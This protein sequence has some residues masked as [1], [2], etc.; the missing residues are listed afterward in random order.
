VD[1]KILGNGGAF[2][3]LST[4]YL[5]ESK[6][7]VDC[8]QT[9]IS[10]MIGDKLY[11]PELDMIEHLFITHIHSD[12]INGLESLLY[13]R[14]I[15]RNFEY[16]NNFTIY[17]T[18]E[19]L[20]YYKSIA[21]SKDSFNNGEYY[22]PFKFVELPLNGGSSILIEDLNIYVNF[23]KAKHM[24][25]SLECLTYIFGDIKSYAIKKIIITGDIDQ[26]SEL[27]TSN[28]IDKNTLIFYDM[29]WTGLPN[30]ER[31]YKFH[32]TEEEIYNIFGKNDNIIGIHT[33]ADL[34]YYEK[35]QINKI[36]K[37]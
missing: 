23:V 14:F 29:G 8:G 13:N 30:V 17:G 35:A 2:D 37:V 21:F 7:L 22:Q 24:N 33:S 19:V 20:E 3:K 12:H 25:N 32:P 5:I 28:M 18:R 31:Y 34:Q 4:A 27:I 11:S 16:D 6:I 9:V 1:C 10:S 15:K 36:Y 26:P